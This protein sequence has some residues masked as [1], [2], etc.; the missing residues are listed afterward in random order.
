MHESKN[1]QIK[2][3][4]RFLIYF[5]AFAITLVIISRLLCRYGFDSVIKEDGIVEWFEFLWCCLSGLFLFRAAHR[6]TD[7]ASL[8]GVL[9]LLPIIA[10]VRELDHVF[11]LIFHGAWVVPAAI[12]ALVAL[13]RTFKSHGSIKIQVLRFLQTQPMILLGIGFF[14]ICVFAQVSGQ[15]VLWKAILGKHYVRNIGRF[16]EEFT[17]FL[18]YIILVIGSLEC[19]L[20]EN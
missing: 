12:I 20:Q 1:A 8:F 18:G 9:W 11:D 6:T 17:E 5:L 2:T 13:Y 3:F 10:A 19:Y 14:I 16:V 7:Y 15:Q 4:K